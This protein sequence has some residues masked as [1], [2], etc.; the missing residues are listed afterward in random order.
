MIAGLKQLCLTQSKIPFYAVDLE[1]F[2]DLTSLH[3]AN[4]QQG[5]EFCS[6]S[7]GMPNRLLIYQNSKYSPLTRKVHPIFPLETI[8]CAMHH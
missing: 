6:H 2:S 1:N 4:D 8:F 3:M 7:I 5:R